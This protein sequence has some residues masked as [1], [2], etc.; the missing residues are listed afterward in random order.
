MEPTH[1]P[2]PGQSD[3]GD[4]D[5]RTGAGRDAYARARSALTEA[6]GRAVDLD[7]G[8]LCVVAGAGSGKTRVLT[9]RVARRILDGTAEAD[10][11]VVC[12]FTRKAA[13]ELR[14]R[15]AAY[16][17][18]VSVPGPAGG[19][20]SPGVRAGTIHQL[21]LALLRKQAADAGRPPPV[22]SDRRRHDVAD[23]LGA[24]GP[25][26]GVDAEIGWAKSRGLGPGEYAGEA[27]RA[28]RRPPV[29]ADEIATVYTAYQ[30]RLARRRQIDLDDLLTHAAA[31]ITDDGAFAEQV[32][33]RYRHLSVDEF[34][35]VTPA[36]YALLRAVL[37]PDGDLC[38]VGDP[39]Q[40]IYG[41]NGADPGLLDALPGLV[42]GM[43]VV[44]LDANHRCTPQVADAAAAALGPVPV[45]APRSQA[46]DG[47]LPTLT[48]YA[49]ERA[50][51]AGVAAQVLA[52]AAGGTDWSDQAVLART[53]DQLA[54][55]RRALE[56]AGV[57]CRFTPPAESDGEPVGTS[58]GTAPSRRP[59]AVTRGDAE[60]GG[61]VELAT[62]HRAKGLEWDAVCVVGLED[63]FV[64]IVHA[65]TPA[66]EAEERRLLYV[67][68]TRAARHLDC[69][70]AR[71]RTTASG[72]TVERKPSP[73]LTALEGRVR[74]GSDRVPPPDAARRF[75][76]LRASLRP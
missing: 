55:V 64:P 57:P 29:A 61:W 10:H 2:G 16:G 35:D 71:R 72:R 76:D 15:L 49:D 17:V 41:W 69:S 34:Q 50:E 70:W 74:T 9:L 59:A 65:A 11:T 31:A 6:Q 54:T 68:L 43:A 27:A 28:G 7:T 4:D 37:G 53:H 51:A 1:R 13:G 60:P 47:P 26:A 25:A 44:H 36:Q 30:E 40:A 42:P 62:F 14:H 21:A 12:T 75:A 8:A 39:N 46:A 5:D 45:A 66:A 22:V 18:D 20:P 56:A 33:W 3:S 73:W 23:L 58:P 24:P 67:A 63:G 19:A 32:R 38:A 52:R 48:A